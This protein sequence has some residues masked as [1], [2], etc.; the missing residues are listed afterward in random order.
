MKTRITSII[1]LLLFSLSPIVQSQTFR[2]SG[3]RYAIGAETGLAV[4]YLAKKHEMLAGISLQ[5]DFPILDQELYSTV[6]SGYNHVFVRPDYSHLVD[7]MNV[8]PLKVGLKYFYRKYL[9]AQSEVGV[10]FLLNK[11]NCV[12]GKNRA[13]VLA[14]QVGALLHTFGSNYID[15]GLRFE[16]TGKFY[17]CDRQNNFVGLRVAWTFSD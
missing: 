7:D 11:T 9:Y 16:S 2:G 1:F 14:P 10:S 13:Y 15:I 3:I 8:I 5:A 12:E 17:V 6:N 4:N